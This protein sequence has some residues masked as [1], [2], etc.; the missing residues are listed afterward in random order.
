MSDKSKKTYP[1]HLPSNA[2]IPPPAQTAASKKW[3][4]RIIAGL[5]VVVLFLLLLRYDVALM[6]FRY[7]LIPEKPEG[8]LKQVLHGFREFAQTMGIVVALCLV[9][10]YDKKHRRQVIVAALLAQLLSCVAYNAIKLT[11]VRYRPNAEIA[12]VKDLDN[13]SPAQTWI[14]FRPGNGEKET[15]SFPSGHS[16]AAFALAGILAFYYRPARGLLWT[17]AAGC[18]LSRYLDA[19]HW[20]SDCLAGATIGYLAAWT[21][22]RMV[23][24]K[25]NKHKS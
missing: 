21:A 23:K 24:H 18:A 17:L 14:G 1:D 22:L 10:I 25:N 4:T 2:T 8:L 11:V 9:A 5:A 6:R 7:L 15:Q 20:P 12:V 19:V 3:L 16:G 13:L